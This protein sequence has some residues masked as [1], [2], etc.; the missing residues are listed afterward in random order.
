MGKDV[1]ASLDSQKFKPESL[2][3]VA[4]VGESHI[5]KGTRYQFSE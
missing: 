1:M 2:H 3:K 5:L 4:Q